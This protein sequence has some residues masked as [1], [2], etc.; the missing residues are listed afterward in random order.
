MVIEKSDALLSMLFE[1][2]TAIVLAGLPVMGISFAIYAW[3]YYSGTLKRY[4]NL[5]EEVGQEIKDTFKEPEEPKKENYVLDKWVEFG[6]GYYGLMALITFVYLELLDILD[7]ASDLTGIPNVGSFIQV[8]I[9]FLIQLIIESFTNL[10]NALMWWS[11][12]GDTLPIGEGAGLYWLGI[13]Y[14]GYLAGEW[15]AKRYV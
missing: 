10:I 6:G 9:E 1:I 11:K 3:A 5:M 12:W 8:M 2:L 15:L 4:D 13:S 7:L 14:L